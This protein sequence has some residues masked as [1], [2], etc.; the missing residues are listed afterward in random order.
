MSDSSPIRRQSRPLIHL[1]AVTKTFTSGSE[2]LL[3]LDDLHLDVGAGTR[4]VISGES[5][6]GKRTL[7]NVISGV[8]SPD[9]GIVEVADTDVAGANEESLTAYRNGV[10][11]LVFQFHYLLRDFSALENVMMPA[12]IAGASRSSASRR[13]AE[14]L[15]AVRVA[16]RL[17]HFPSQLSGGERQRVAIARALMND[18]AVILADEPTGNLDEANSDNV[19]ALLFDLVAHENRTLVVVSHDRDVA[20]AGDRVLHLEHGKLVGP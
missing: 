6:S 11:G 20:A 13:A 8:D 12:L 15:E 2:R 7:L 19:V 4:L 17:D 14:L 16:E 9:S 1:E 18:P 10:I 3:V 5:G